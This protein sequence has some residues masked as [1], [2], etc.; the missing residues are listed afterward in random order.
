MI[1][2]TIPPNPIKPKLTKKE[3]LTPLI[4]IKLIKERAIT[5]AVPK[6]GSNIIKRKKTPIKIRIGKTPF[7]ILRNSFLFW[8]KYLETKM[9]KPILAN[10]LG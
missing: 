10:S 9:I 6:S 5:I 3:S 2:R 7:F 1:S 8:A 4:K